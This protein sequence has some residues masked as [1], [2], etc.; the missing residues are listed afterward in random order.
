M[1][2]Q[3]RTLS[4]EIV[5]SG[6]MRAAPRPWLPNRILDQPLPLALSSV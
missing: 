3:L 5:P 4:A 1:D 6:F 2:E